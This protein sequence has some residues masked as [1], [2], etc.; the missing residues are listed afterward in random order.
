MNKYKNRLTFAYYSIAL[1]DFKTLQGVPKTLQ[2][3]KSKKAFFK[4][5]PNIEIP[6]F[7]ISN[8][9]FLLVF[10]VVTGTV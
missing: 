4:S 8:S 9:D 7:M 5:C 3:L 10:P 1:W 2:M 6:L